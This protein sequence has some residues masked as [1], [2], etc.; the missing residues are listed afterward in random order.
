MEKT[1]KV[2]DYFGNVGTT[3]K[4]EG[5]RY[6][7][8]DMLTIVILGSFCD[9]RNISQVHEWASNS[10]VQEVFSTY[11]GITSIPCYFWLCCLLKLIK[12]KSFNEYFIN[13]VESLIPENM[14]GLT[15]LF[16]GKTIRSTSKMCCVAQFSE[17]LL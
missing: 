13:W 16:D 10:R 12:P 7:V 11:F 9:L 17:V 6:N 3:K 5:Y 2:T 1:L 8:G 14:K 15:I 4:H